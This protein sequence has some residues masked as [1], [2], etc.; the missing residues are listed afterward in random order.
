MKLDLYCW[1]TLIHSL[2]QFSGAYPLLHRYK[3]FAFHVQMLKYMYKKPRH[4]H[5]FKIKGCKAKVLDLLL[6]CPMIC[7]SSRELL[8][9]IVVHLTYPPHPF[10]FYLSHSF[11][12]PFFDMLLSLNLYPF[13]STITEG[14]KW[15]LSSPNV[16]EILQF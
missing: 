10:F 9:V 5:L 8:E 3:N 7:G 13:N 1:T 12:M 11:D 14:K 4:I 16:K 2:S 15:K 6:L